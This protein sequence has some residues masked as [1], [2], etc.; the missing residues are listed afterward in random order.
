MGRHVD[1]FTGKKYTLT[2][3]SLELKVDNLNSNSD[4]FYL[5]KQ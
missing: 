5:Q 4:R 2:D 1:S 3:N